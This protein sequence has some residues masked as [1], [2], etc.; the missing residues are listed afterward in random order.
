V[1][2]K[3]F[4]DFMAKMGL[5]VRDDPP[6]VIDFAARQWGPPANGW[7]L[8]VKAIPAAESG[9]SPSL[10]IVIRNVGPQTQTLTIAVSKNDRTWIH[11]YTVELQEANGRAVPLAAFGRTALD[12]ARRA[13][14]FEAELAPGAWNETVLPLG[15]F[16]N[17]RGNNNNLRAAASATL[18]PGLALQSNTTQV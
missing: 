11:F 12:P 1:G 14:L 5:A 10:S 15:S 4:V 8:S 18:S 9:D 2:L 17:V 13:E 16:F 3:G 6:K 7:T